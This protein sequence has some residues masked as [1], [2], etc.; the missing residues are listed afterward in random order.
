MK[1]KV[2]FGG[3]TRFTQALVRAGARLPT[4]AGRLSPC[5][6][7]LDCGFRVGVRRSGINRGRNWSGCSTTPGSNMSADASV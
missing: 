7:S 6:G 3:E 5:C 2:Q 1:L 4:S